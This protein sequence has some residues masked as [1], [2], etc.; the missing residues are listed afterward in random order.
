MNRLPRRVG[1]DIGAVRSERRLSQVLPSG[2]TA[3]DLRAGA[4]GHVP[5]SAT[6]PVPRR[7]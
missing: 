4:E 6:T 5:A 7:G 1:A 2:S 3:P